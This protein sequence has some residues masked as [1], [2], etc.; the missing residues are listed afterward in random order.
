MES[1]YDI[2]F[3]IGRLIFCTYIPRVAKLQGWFIAI[4]YPTYIHPI[5][6]WSKEV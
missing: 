1:P 4:K 6:D 5:F 3:K 2:K